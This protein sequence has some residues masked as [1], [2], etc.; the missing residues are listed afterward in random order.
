MKQSEWVR[1]VVEAFACEIY[2]KL[3]TYPYEL[4]GC[5]LSQPKLTLSA[6]FTTS[7]DDAANHSRP[8]D[9][10]S[11]WTTITC[12][13]TIDLSWPSKWITSPFS[14]QRTFTH[15]GKSHAST[16]SACYYFAAPELRWNH[17]NAAVLPLV[18]LLPFQ[19]V[20]TRPLLRH[21]VTCNGVYSGFPWISPPILFWGTADCFG[22]ANP[23]TIA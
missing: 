19:S 7:L 13:Q 17:R 3:T 22:F 16:L 2:F 14:T 1:L 23:S 4:V 6:Y 9:W 11:K 15:H 8:T 5:A 21:S 12:S 18:E 10:F 20:V